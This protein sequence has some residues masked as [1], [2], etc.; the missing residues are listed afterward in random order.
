ME[1]AVFYR[2]TSDLSRRLVFQISIL[3]VKNEIIYRH[4]ETN[5]VDRHRRETD[6]ENQRR[7]QR[8]N[9]H[10]KDCQPPHRYEYPEAD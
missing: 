6:V 1:V 8:G 5:Y 10:T 7:Y 3:E 9:Y 4:A 2:F